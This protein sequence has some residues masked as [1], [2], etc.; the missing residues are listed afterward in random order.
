VRAETRSAV[1]IRR[2]VIVVVVVVDTSYTIVI[3]RGGGSRLGSNVLRGMRDMPRR[4][5]AHRWWKGVDM[6]RPICLSD[7]GHIHR[8][9]WN[10]LCK[11]VVIREQRDAN[12]GCVRSREL[13]PRLSNEQVDVRTQRLGERGTER[14]DERR[15][16]LAISFSNGRMNHFLFY[17]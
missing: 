4:L 13:F 17:L 16:D 9:R 10:L 1:C 8:R 14:R 2:A 3:C 6:C 7:P 12:F 11:C 5:K 15:T